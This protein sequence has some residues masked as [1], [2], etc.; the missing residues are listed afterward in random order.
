MSG[1]ENSLPPLDTT[2]MNDTDWMDDINYT[3]IKNPILPHEQL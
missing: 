1:I 3:V 2:G